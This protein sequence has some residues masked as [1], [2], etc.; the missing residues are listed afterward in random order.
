MEYERGVSTIV[1]EILII[2]IT[3][4]LTIIILNYG[5]QNLNG[6][7][8]GNIY[9]NGTYKINGNNITI[10]ITYG[11]LPIPFYILILNNGNISK[12]LIN[13]MK[14]NVYNVTLGTQ[15]I[16]VK[17]NNYVNSDKLTAGDTIVIGGIPEN[18]I[19]GTTF[20]IIYENRV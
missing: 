13:N 18:N 2:S 17:L 5:F 15:N 6:I 16:Y 11:T 20:M 8:S 9:L 1:S 4:I 19:K 12:I 3:F 14:N 10:E 7:Q